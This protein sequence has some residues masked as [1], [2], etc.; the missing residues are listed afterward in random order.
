MTRQTPCGWEPNLIGCTTG[1][2]CEG[3][4]DFD[5]ALLELVE[6]VSATLI[7]ALTGRRFGLCPYTVRPCKPQTCE[8]ISLAEDILYFNRW[9]RETMGVSVGDF[10]P[11]LLEG[12]V[13]NIACGCPQ[14]CC[15]CRS[16]CEVWLPGPVNSIVSVTNGGILVEPE[17]YQLYSDS[18]LVFYNG[19]CPDCQDY[20]KPLGEPGTWSV[21]YLKGEP[22]P[23]I[24]N[25]A[26][27]MYACELGRALSG[28]K[29]CKIP[30]RVQ[31]IARQGIN[32]AFADPFLLAENLLTGVPEIDLFIKA[33]NPY[34]MAQPPRV[35]SPDLPVVRR[36]V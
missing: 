25:L 30:S 8:T 15:K 34:Q 36:E 5:P 1:P 33:M 31:N 28:D 6:D 23:D 11:I 32:E 19:Q 18:K 27:G 35:W 3:S 14:G 24:L 17:N 21:T 26:A 9:N 20:D 22:V 2:C 12:K 13:Y 4:E 7:W 10:S 16:S 29:S